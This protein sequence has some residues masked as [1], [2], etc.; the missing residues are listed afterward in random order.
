MRNKYGSWVC[1]GAHTGNL[2]TWEAETG[3]SWVRG[4]PQQLSETLSNLARP[5]FQ[6]RNK[7]G[8]GVQLKGRMPMG[9][10]PSTEKKP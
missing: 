6:I 10:I 7:I 9:S 5:C 8:L 1:S 2:S 4:Q 3:G